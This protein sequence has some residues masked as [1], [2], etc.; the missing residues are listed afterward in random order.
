MQKLPAN[1]EVSTLLPQTF[2]LSAVANLELARI[3][4]NDTERVI[5]S[6]KNRLHGFI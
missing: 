4:P 1:A 3:L 2:F 5:V 6:L